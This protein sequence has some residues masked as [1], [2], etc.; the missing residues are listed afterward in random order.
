MYVCCTVGF[1]FLWHARQCTL[2]LLQRS[3]A[4]LL[5]PLSITLNT[6]SITFMPSYFIHFP[7]SSLSLVSNSDHTR[8]PASLPGDWLARAKCCPL[9]L[10]AQCCT[11]TTLPL[12]RVYLTPAHSMCLVAKV[13]AMQIGNTALAQQ[14]ATHSLG[15][16]NV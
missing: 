10:A 9:G 4:G 7:F 11:L 13:Y 2:V 1:W 15:Q 3:A 6:H 8:E 14:K 12:L 5:Q 16:L